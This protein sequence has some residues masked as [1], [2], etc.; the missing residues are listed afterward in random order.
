MKNHRSPEPAAHSTLLSHFRIR[1]FGKSYRHSLGGSE[2]PTGS[3][4]ALACCLWRPR[5]RPAV[6]VISRGFRRGRRKQH[7]RARV[8]PK[9][10]PAVGAFDEGGIEGDD[11]EEGAYPELLFQEE[12]GDLRFR[13][14]DGGVDEGAMHA[15]R[16]ARVSRIHFGD[17]RRSSTATTWR[18]SPL[19]R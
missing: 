19:S 2:A 9:I 6:R 8:L 14:A 10:F 7:A 3:T 5:R 12:L 15:Y 11:F 17:R 16:P 13:E 1:T 18:M 4:R